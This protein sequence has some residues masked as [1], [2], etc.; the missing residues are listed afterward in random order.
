[1]DNAHVQQKIEWILPVFNTLL[2]FEQDKCRLLV[3]K[4]NIFRAKIIYKVICVYLTICKAISKV[5]ICI[6][7]CTI[8]SMYIE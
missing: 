7:A 6:N 4:F 3:M 2:L 8:K 5:Y 1:M